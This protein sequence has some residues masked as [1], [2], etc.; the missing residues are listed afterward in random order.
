VI[1]LFRVSN[2]REP[3]CSIR[4]RTPNTTVVAKSRR[5]RYCLPFPPVVTKT[6]PVLIARNWLMRAVYRYSLP[7]LLSCWLVPGSLKAQELKCDAVRPL[8]SSSSGYKNRGNRCEGLYVADIGSRSIDIISLTFGGVRYDLNS[9][10][11]LRLSVL[12][13]SSSVNIRAVA[14]TPKTYYRM[15]TLLQRGATLFWPVTDVLLPEHLTDNRIGIFGWTGTESSKIFVP[16][17]VV[18][19]PATPPAPANDHVTLLAQFSSDADSIK[20]RWAHAQ[21][22]GCS[23]SGKWDDAIGNPITAN[24]PVKI[25]LSKLS[26]GVDCVE[27][28]A[29]SKASNDWVTLIIR[30]EIP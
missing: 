29:R 22:S 27:F 21:G 18:T 1:C 16:V 2:R 15:D 6:G 20:W 26:S 30:V 11:T 10:P 13:K 28:A 19:E 23:A 17:R 14:V 8:P 3:S 24:S 5:T 9:K 12:G 4:L 7:A 25:D